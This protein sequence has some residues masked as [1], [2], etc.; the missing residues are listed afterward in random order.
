[1]SVSNHIK[2]HLRPLPS[3]P[4]RLE[5]EKLSS[6]FGGCVGAGAACSRDSDCCGGGW[7]PLA[8]RCTSRIEGFRYNTEYRRVWRCRYGSRD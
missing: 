3:R 6:I 8:L 7:A 1:M 2:I 4:R 5:V